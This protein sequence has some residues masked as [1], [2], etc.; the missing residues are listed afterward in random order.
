M[1]KSLTI[2]ESKA[3]TQVALEDLIAKW[4]DYERKTNDA[5][6]NTVKA[7]WR[8][9][10]SFVGW[11]VGGGLSS[12][13]VTPQT[14]ESYKTDLKAK[15]SPQ[16]VNL[17]LTAV[18]SFY[19]FMVT[20][21]HIP[22]NP[23]SEIKGV[24]RRESKSHKRQ[25]LTNGEVLDVLDT[26]DTGTLSGL[27][28]KTILVLFTRCAL[29]TVEVHRAN[30]G[31]LKT[32]G[33]RLTL[34]VKG[35]GDLT[36]EAGVYVL[37]P[38]DQEPLVRAWVS[39]RKALGSSKPIDPLFV[40]LSNRTRG[41]RLSLRPI[42]RMVKSRYEKAKVVGDAKTTHSLRHSAITNAIRHGAT[43][44]QVQSM[45]RHK[46]FDTTLGYFHEVERIDNPAEDLIKY[47]RREE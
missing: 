41:Q 7:Y 3:L 47:E 33:D 15:Y 43:P 34:D 40:S 25:P 19:R 10:M 26:C 38:L 37:V 18:R 4:L 23:A 24:K 1:S 29:R 9:L 30:I 6:E 12:R 44:L 39:K 22:Y 2:Q 42:R 14:I 16:T 11:L 35:K 8:G 36:N 32:R 17:K 21:G 13:E 5:S 45:A 31:D 28:D 27:R 20:S 46:S